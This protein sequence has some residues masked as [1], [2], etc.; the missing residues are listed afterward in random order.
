MSQGV[1]ALTCCQHFS[2]APVL[3]PESR[4]EF[5]LLSRLNQFTRAL[6]YLV[7]FAEWKEHGRKMMQT[8]QEGS[9]GGRQGR[10]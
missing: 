8:K 3:N 7:V 10:Q 6:A 2:A 9:L 4:P 5:S 1:S